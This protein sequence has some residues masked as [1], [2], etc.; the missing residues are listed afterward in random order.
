M[1]KRRKRKLTKRTWM[2]LY[3][4]KL[5]AL[6]MLATVIITAAFLPFNK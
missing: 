5:A 2:T 1:V 3:C 6:L 4:C